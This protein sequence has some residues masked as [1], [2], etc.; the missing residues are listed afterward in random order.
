MDSK[1]KSFAIAT[2]RRGSL[3]WRPRNEAKTKA[4]TE[5]KINESTGRLSWHSKCNICGV[6][7]AD[8]IMELDHII[9]CVSSKGWTNFNDFI[10]ILYSDIDNFQVICDQCH[11]IKSLAEGQVRKKKRKKSKKKLDNC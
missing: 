11:Y 7:K 8:G 3:R 5:R 2:L 4:R 9:P 1:K 10:E 6:E